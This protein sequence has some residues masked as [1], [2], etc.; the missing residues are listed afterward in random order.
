MSEQPDRE[1]IKIGEA[2]EEAG[3]SRRTLRYYEELDLLQP[4][5]SSDGGFRRYSRE[6][7]HRVR[8]IATFKQLGFSLQDIKPILCIEPE[9][10]AK[11]EQLRYS[12]KILQQQLTEINSRLQELN[13]RR[14]Q[15]K[16]ALQILTEC[17]QCSVKRCPSDC[18]NREAFLCSSGGR[19]ESQEEEK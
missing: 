7:L 5:K 6:D 4:T 9:E 12:R 14:D 11:A 1:L 3:V 10:D 18:S 16:D 13:Q 2:A 17:R 19:E 15:V 8:V